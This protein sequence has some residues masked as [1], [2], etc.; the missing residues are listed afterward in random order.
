MKKFFLGLLPLIKV[1]LNMFHLPMVTVMR[2]HNHTLTHTP[3][4][5]RIRHRDLIMA[6]CL[7]FLPHTI[8][9]NHTSP[10]HITLHHT[11]PRHTTLD[12]ITPH[13]SN[14]TS[15]KSQTTPHTTPPLTPCPASAYKGYHS[16]C[17][18]LLAVLYQSIEVSKYENIRNL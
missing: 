14:H 4:H 7:H 17:I 6:K 13:H 12:Y 16:P 18:R 9:C 11:I 15:Q 1:G 8:L 3:T 2:T 5:T 10:H